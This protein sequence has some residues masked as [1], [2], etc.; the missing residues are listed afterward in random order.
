MF[1]G[2]ED[3]QQQEKQDSALSLEVFCQSESILKKKKWLKRI[4]NADSL[5]I[6]FCKDYQWNKYNFAERK[7]LNNTIAAR[8]IE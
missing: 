7:F 6:D 2:K 3:R 4:G 1:Q 5:Q 8:T